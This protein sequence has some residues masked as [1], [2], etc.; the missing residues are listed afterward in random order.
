V[1][2]SGDVDGSHAWIAFLQDPSH[3]DAV[4]PLGII[5]MANS[6]LAQGKK[7]GDLGLDLLARL[8]LP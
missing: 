4:A 2:K 8:P 7:L 1:E 3:P 6:D 5:V